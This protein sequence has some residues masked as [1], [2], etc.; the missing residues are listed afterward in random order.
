[1]SFK[2]V[3]EIIHFIYLIMP[4]YNLSNKT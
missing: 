2:N 1:M 4:R 3:Q